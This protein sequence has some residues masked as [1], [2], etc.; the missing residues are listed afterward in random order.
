MVGHIS[1][2]CKTQTGH[3]RATQRKQHGFKKNPNKNGGIIL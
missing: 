1:N 3:F 2:G